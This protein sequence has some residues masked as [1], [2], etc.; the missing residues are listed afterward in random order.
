MDTVKFAIK[1]S[2]TTAKKDFYG[3][4]YLLINSDTE[5]LE[6]CDAVVTSNGSLLDSINP[7]KSFSSF[8]S[9]I[10]TYKFQ[11]NYLQTSSIDLQQVILRISKKH[12]SSRFM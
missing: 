10:A 5:F 3:V 9:S 8:A 11:G 12:G 1:G 7:K 2:L 4:F 6:K